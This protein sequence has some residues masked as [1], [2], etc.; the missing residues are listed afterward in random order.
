VP[1]PADAGGVRP[2][3]LAAAL[4]RSGARLAYLQP[5]WA[6][7]TGTT[8]DA[9]RRPLVL[10][11]VRRAGALVIED[12]WSRD[13]PIDGP[14]PPPL[15]AADDDGHVVYVRSLTKSAAPGLRVAA[16]GARGAAGARLRAAR[17]VDDFFV[18][19]PLQEAVLDLLGSPGWRR[20]L[21][22]LPGHLRERR[23][24]LLAAVGRELPAWRVERPG[25]GFHVWARLPDGTDDAA[26]AAEA[27]A[28][29][30]AV[31][32]GGPWFAAEAPAPHLR[33]TFAAAPP[34]RLAEGV[35]RLAVA[36]GS[37]SSAR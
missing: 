30:V 32:P 8:L 5:L 10:E 6:N 15:A 4:E 21:R 13:L 24:A 9:D 26:L 25:G 37:T 23:D 2:D 34:E 33:L 36:A 16:I 35:R 14:A 12:D 1:V 22:A 7:P 28:H 31:F 11:A 3:H 27:A 20:H 29:G 17:V 19:G 18:A